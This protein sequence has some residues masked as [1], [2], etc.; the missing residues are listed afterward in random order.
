MYIIHMLI[1]I[2]NSL[3]QPQRP[4]SQ[5]PWL[6]CVFG[7]TSTCFS[8]YVNNLSPLGFTGSKS[9]VWNMPEICIVRVTAKKVTGN[10][11]VLFWNFRT[12]SH[13]PWT[14]GIDLWLRF[15]F[16][17]KLHKCWDTKCLY[18]LKTVIYFEMFVIG[19]HIKKQQKD[20][21]IRNCNLY[22]DVV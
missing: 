20:F 5:R 11:T 9:W 4:C 17:L 15:I 7:K 18:G 12:E 2:W 21:I 22:Y 16:L 8:Q 13:A 6:L 10:Y 14:V 1:Y 19:S 3:P